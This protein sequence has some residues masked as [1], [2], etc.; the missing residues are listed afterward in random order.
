MNTYD[1]S[2]KVGLVT[3]A[4]SGI[5]RAIAMAFAKSGARVL[6]ADINRANGE[7]TVEMIRQSGGEAWFQVCDVSV[8]SDVESMIQGVVKA[9]GRL[10]FAVNNAAVELEKTS[11]VDVPEEVFDR[12]VAVNVK[13]VFLCMQHQIRQMALQRKGAIVNITSVNSFRPQPHQTVYTGSKHAVLGMT[14]NAAM[15]CASSGVRINAISP[16]AIE[17][18]M[19]EQSLANSPIPRDAIIDRMSLNGRFGRPEEIARAALW[20]CSDDASYTYGH[21]LSVDGGY[22]A[23]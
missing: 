15:E 8:A 10:D 17:T 6:V 5:G 19:L 18:P 16:G 23:R 4:G 12:L 2:D 11:L 21:A 13:G 7:A 20:L 1:Y 9:H 3:G 14:R 22:L